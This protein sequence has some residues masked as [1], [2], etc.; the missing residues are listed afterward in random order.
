M[1]VLPGHHVAQRIFLTKSPSNEELHALFLMTTLA[2]LEELNWN[3]LE[4]SRLISDLTMFFKT[5]SSLVNSSFPPEMVPGLIGT[6]QSHDDH[7]VRRMFSSSV[8]VSC[9]NQ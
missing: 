9:Q 5:N 2:L 3:W 4:E 6:R 1:P 8:L 7:E